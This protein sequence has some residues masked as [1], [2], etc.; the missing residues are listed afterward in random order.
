[1][2]SAVNRPEQAEPTLDLLAI[3][4]RLEQAEPQEILRWS[5]ETFAPD[6]TLA[7][8]FGGASGMALLDMAIKIAPHLPVF[9]LDTDL[10]FPETY[11]TRDRAIARYGIQPQGFRSTLT[12]AEQAA[13]YG[14]DLWAHDPDLCCRLR[15]VEPNARALAGR[16]A[17]ITAIRRDQT[18]NRRQTPVVAWDEKFG[19]VKVAPLAR[20]DERQVWAYLLANDVPYNPLHDRGYPSIGCAPCTRPVR[21]GEDPRA[22]RWS[23][24]DKS[25]CGLHTP[26]P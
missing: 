13:C 3:A 4:A 9:Y 8:S 22:G 7:C 20:W 26:S 10:L 23:G 12:L 18:A 5:I 24:S 15:K 1:M 14:D 2:V 11:A 6:V 19:L 16:R 17:W 25:E 21:P